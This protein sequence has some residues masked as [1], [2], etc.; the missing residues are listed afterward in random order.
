MS[1]AWDSTDDA[2]A[3]SEELSA[4]M[5]DQAN[6][7]GLSVDRLKTE[8][9]R[10]Q[11]VLRVLCKYSNIKI[12]SLWKLKER[13]RHASLL[14]SYVKGAGAVPLAPKHL[15]QKNYVVP[16]DDPQ[17]S[18]ILNSL[19]RKYEPGF[20]HFKP[21]Q[22]GLVSQMPKSGKFVQTDLT[23]E[24]SAEYLI[25]IPFGS[26]CVQSEGTISVPNFLLN[27][28][29]SADSFCLP[30]QSMLNAVLS[31]LT[32]G[33]C[34]LIDRRIGMITESMSS[35]SLEGENAG[36]DLAIESVLSKVVPDF[37]RSEFA[38]RLAPKVD[39][40]FEL[41]FAR[42]VNRWR[43]MDDEDIPLSEADANDMGDQFH[44]LFRN[45]SMESSVTSDRRTD[46]MVVPTPLLERIQFCFPAQRI[47]SAIVGEVRN[48]SG[49]SAE[50][51]LLL[52][53]RVNDLS[54]INGVG[55]TTRDYFDWED[56]IYLSTICS[57]LDFINELFVAEE[58]RLR[59]A[60]ILSHEMHAPTSF[61]YA[62]AERLRNHFDGKREMP[63]KMAA[64]EMRD[65]LAVSELQ[66]ALIDRLMIGLQVG[67]VAPS[68][69]Y[70]VS[71]VRTQHIADEVVRMVLPI[72][73]RN[74]VPQT[75]IKMT[76]FPTLFIDRRAI[77]QILL[78]ITTNAI[79]YCDPSRKQDFY[80]RAYA[81]HC[82]VSELSSTN[83]P[84][85][86]LQKLN[87]LSMNRGTLMTFEDGGIGIPKR[88]QNTIFKAG[89]RGRSAEVLAQIGVGLGL[90][91]V[92]NI[93]RDHFGD[94][95]LEN[96]KGPTTFQVFFP[97]MVED[98]SYQ[99][100]IEWTGVS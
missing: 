27:L 17:L 8:L 70:R 42:R 63:K 38:I 96:H 34:A 46:A 9:L 77:L 61:V 47:V 97:Q 48:R 71:R 7:R 12:A 86:T 67:A 28:F 2:L 32:S 60:H 50:G 82:T 43:P 29:C 79:K 13:A 18:S 90:S 11:D 64:R 62:T 30:N 49:T 94:I 15:R 75:N 52:L 65:I 78:N 40:G 26:L 66:S 5:I 39:S 95:W 23:S 25:A 89:V 98:G 4:I 22:F 55:G 36:A 21:V 53:N 99:K 6:G 57:V 31:K 24:H 68:Q 54:R 3:F 16:F 33:V 51:Y 93:A 92:R 58:T 59:G 100:L 56:E 69:K 91:V 19:E 84:K 44:E 76:S 1:F 88:M 41:K 85:A 35:V 73:R 81:E 80:L 20:G 10:L 37:I 72:C 74:E 87:S 45:R 83:M 14:T